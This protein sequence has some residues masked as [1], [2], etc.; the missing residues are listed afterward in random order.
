MFDH[1]PVAPLKIKNRGSRIRSSTFGGSASVVPDSQEKPVDF[2][3]PTLIIPEE[4]KEGCET[5]SSTVSTETSVSE[6]RARLKA[7]LVDNEAIGPE[8]ARII[9][10]IADADP[11]SQMAS[12]LTIASSINSEKHDFDFGGTPARKDNDNDAEDADADAEEA[13]VAKE[14]AERL[15]LGSMLSDK[16]RSKTRSA[17]SM[18]RPPSARSSRRASREN[19][20]RRSGPMLPAGL[21]N[22]APADPE[23][24]K[25]LPDPNTFPI[26]VP[27]ME[28]LD[29][30][31]ESNSLNELIIKPSPLPKLK[32]VT[33]FKGDTVLL[34]SSKAPLSAV[35]TK[36]TMSTMSTMSGISALGNAVGLGLGPRG[37]RK[38]NRLTLT[39]PRSPMSDAATAAAAL[40]ERFKQKRAALAQMGPQG[41]VQRRHQRNGS[42]DGTGRTRMPLTGSGFFG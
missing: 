25:A 12:L 27:P 6:H 34:P 37:P 36:S 11:D 17:I 35:S 1:P 42:K 26:P 22:L 30:A 23:A 40:V 20:L 4:T 14:K 5:F 38:M 2:I 33:K 8:L 10:S 15:S 29:M 32:I 24:L 39:D 13:A 9:H 41:G 3:A 7:E 28:V 21:K 19:L 16:R 31:P 18:R